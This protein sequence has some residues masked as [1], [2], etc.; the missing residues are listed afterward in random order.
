MSDGGDNIGGIV[1][2]GLGRSV[3]FVLWI[4]DIRYID[5]IISSMGNWEG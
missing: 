5:V 1:G 4:Y 3:G 2:G